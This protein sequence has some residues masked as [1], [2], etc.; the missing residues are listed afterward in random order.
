MKNALNYYYDLKIDTIHQKDKNYY[1]NLNKRK[2][3]LL[4]S[5]EI[6][7]LNEIYRLSEFLNINKIVLNKDKQIITNIND[8]NYILL[9]INIENK[10]INLSDIIELNNIQYYLE[11]KL[12]KINW[13]KLWTEKIDYFEYQI[14]QFGKKYPI[15]RECINYYIGLAECAIA[16][17][18]NTG[19]NVYLSLS[20]Y[21]VTTNSFDLY[22]PLN[23]IIDYRVRDVCEYIKYCFFND[24][25]I[26]KEINLFLSYNNLTPDECN[27]FIARLMFPTYFFDM[28]EDI[29]NNKIE[30]QY[31]KKIIS[32][33]DKYEK[34][35]KYIY[36]Q[37]RNNSLNIDW[38]N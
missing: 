13:F 17:V 11:N 34:F 9:K 28:Y 38:L 2:Y 15:I 5:Y 6:D 4:E 25:D 36:Q 37:M 21:R 33:V 32:K 8:K 20:H 30:E 12:L 31:I 3:V 18:K 1:F 29:I 14:N 19:S 22:N 23:C 35:L 7:H 26:E 24:I 10:K 27:L 16:I